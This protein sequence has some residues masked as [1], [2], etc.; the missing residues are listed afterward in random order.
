MPTIYPRTSL[1]DRKFAWNFKVGTTPDV[2]VINLGTNDFSRDNPDEIW[3]KDSYNR[4]L[5]LVRKQYPAA[6][7]FL[8]NGPMLSPGEKLTRL[9]K[10][11]REIV[12][13][14]H[15]A[16]DAKIHALDFPVQDAADGLG[17]DWHPNVKTHEK[18]ATLLASAIK[19]ATGW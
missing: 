4:L 10:W 15:A 7:V 3:W 6:H 19:A 16:G 13:S 11:N 5:G 8:T 17:A 2:V 18:M 12:E 9:Q 1:L 14:R